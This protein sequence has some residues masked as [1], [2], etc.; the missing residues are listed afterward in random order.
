MADILDYLDWRGDI[1][2]EYS[3]FNEID[4]LILTQ[5]VYL[6][7]EGIVDS[8]WDSKIT[9]EEAGKK[10]LQIY[11]NEDE[12]LTILINSCRDVLRKMIKSD[13]FRYLKL[14]NYVQKYDTVTSKQFAAMTVELSPDCAFVIFRGTDDT[15]TG[16]EEDFKLCYMTPVAS[17]VEAE[18]Y[19]K[20]VCRVCKHDIIIGGHSKGGNLSIYAAMCQSDED[21]ERISRIYNFDGPGFLREIVER[22]DYLKIIPKVYTYMPQGSVVGMIMYNEG[23]QSIV[24]STEKGFLQHTAI[25]WQVWGTH[26]IFEEKFDRNSILFNKATKNWVE[27]IDA[28]KREQFIEHIFQLLKSGESETL[29]E[30]TAGLPQVMNKIIHSYSDLD[31]PTRRILRGIVG[32]MLKITTQ[33]IRENRIVGRKDEDEQ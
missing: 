7:F 12:S 4:G 17:Q 31:K 1:P 8:G 29:T 22:D 18:I 13:R 25:S 9:V 20:D 24:K 26:F 11:D 19:L 32:Q 30:I 21:K 3:P 28:D 16:W 23:S 14:Y 15:L 5:F 27:E 6:P 33:T 10:Y 2:M